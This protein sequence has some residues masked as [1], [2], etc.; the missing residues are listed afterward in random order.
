M[1]RAAAVT[2]CLVFLFAFSL[3]V[4]VAQEKATKQECVAK[5]REAVA[6]LKQIGLEAAKAK[7]QDPNGPFVWKDSYVFVQNFDELMVVHPNPKLVGKSMKGNK[8]ISG[9]MFNAEMLQIATT[10]GE[11]WVSYMWPK[12]GDKDPS[13]KTSFVLRVP[14]ENLFVGAGIYQ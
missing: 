1:K 5:C 2:T 3:A 13:P 11:G 6:L 14:G 7:L 9:K 4:S 12:L 10:T 8:D